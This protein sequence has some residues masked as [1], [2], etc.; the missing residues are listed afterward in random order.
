MISIIAVAFGV[1]AVMVY[2]SPPTV[3]QENERIYL[4]S[5]DYYNPWEGYVKASDME[6]NSFGVFMYPSSYNYSNPANAYQKF[7]LIRLPSWLGGDKNDTSAFRAYSMLD[8]ESHCLLR[9][10]PQDGRQNIED[11]CHIEKY[12]PFDGA[13]YFFGIKYFNKPVENALPELDLGTDNNGFL[14][15]KPPTWTVD[16]NGLIGDGRHLSKDAILRSSQMMLQDYKDTAK[17]GIN[18]PLEFENGTQFLIDITYSNDQT[19]FRYTTDSSISN[20][21]SIITLRYCNCTKPSLQ[22]I[23]YFSQKNLQVWK[24]DDK[25]IYALPAHYGPNNTIYYKFNFY[26][27]G[28]EVTFDPGKPFAEGIKLTLDALFNGTKLSDLQQIAYNP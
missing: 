14:Y 27:N 12:R 20:Y 26:E 5:L 16:R 3:S 6:P 17:N 22:D 23:P 1:Y 15:V 28:C 10:W 4:H 9:Y 8:V 11:V 19:Q 21:Y 7:L 18:I 13:S 25:L 24:F 2:S